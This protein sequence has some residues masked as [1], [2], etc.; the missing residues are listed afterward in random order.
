M[1]SLKK[2]NFKSRR[3]ISEA[4]STILAFP[5]WWLMTAIFLVLFLWLYSLGINTIGVTRGS[6]AY[7]RGLDAETYRRDFIAIGLGGL[8]KPYKDASYTKVGGRGVV[9]GLESTGTW[10]DYHPFTVKAGTVVRDEQFYPQAP[11]GGRE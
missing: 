1:P 10:G 11:A 2:L 8:A 6:E 4:T 5:A 9:I 7:A 3:G